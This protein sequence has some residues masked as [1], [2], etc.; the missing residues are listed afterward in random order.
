[1][2]LDYDRGY[3]D[4]WIGRIQKEND[5]SEY[6]QGYLEGI[7]DRAQSDQEEQDRAFYGDKDN[8]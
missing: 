1:M 4:G 8:D 5:T 3:E 6:N 2:E 7:Y